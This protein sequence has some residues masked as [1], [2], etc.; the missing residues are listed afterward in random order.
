[1]GRAIAIANQKGGVGKTTTSINLSSSLAARGKKVLVIDIDPQGNTTSGFGIEKNNLENTI[2]ELILGECSVQD[3][4]IKDV[5]PNVSLLPS[6]V[7]L[8][9]AEIEL[10][11]IEKKEYILKKEIEWIK[12]DYDYIIIFVH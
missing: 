7:N 8:A 3:S 10:I 9:A 6:N 4:I 2:Y 11:G 12:D 1:M 5:I